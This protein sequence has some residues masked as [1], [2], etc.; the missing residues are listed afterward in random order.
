MFRFGIVLS[1]VL[2]AIGLLAAGVVAGSL[3]LVYVS[4]GV[5]VLAALLLVTFV[6][7]WRHEIFGSSA[8]P[9]PAVRRAAGLARVCGDRA[10]APAIETVAEP[11]A[12]GAPLR[13]R[14]ADAE[15]VSSSLDSS[16]RAVRV[17]ATHGAGP[18]RSR[19]ARHGS[20]L[21]SGA[22]PAG[23]GPGQGG[24]HRAPA[25]GRPIGPERPTAGRCQ[26][27]GAG[28]WGAGVAGAGVLAL[29]SLVRKLPSWPLPQRRSRRPLKRWRSVRSGRRKRTGTQPAAKIAG[30]RYAGASTAR[31]KPSP[32]KPSKLHLPQPVG[33]PASGGVARRWRRIGRQSGPAG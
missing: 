10:D 3:L 7:I 18:A 26:G 22:T 9:G 14:A 30:R 15:R 13:G 24:G 11:V 6:V 29:P 33:H 4:I 32:A 1:V 17:P 31:L 28:I 21:A 2:I 8:A 5:A 19:T 20:V 16:R 25:R 23:T 27:S 12:A